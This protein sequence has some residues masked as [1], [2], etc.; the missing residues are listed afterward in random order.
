MEGRKNKW[1]QWKVFVFIKNDRKCNWNKVTYI[2][3]L[4]IYTTNVHEVA[5]VRNETYIDYI[6]VVRVRQ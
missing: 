3:H 5:S 2:I 4:F 1:K 6:L